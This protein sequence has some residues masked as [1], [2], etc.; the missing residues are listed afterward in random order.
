MVLHLG[1][2]EWVIVDS[3][4]DSKTKRPC[5]LTYLEGIGVDLQ[6]VKYIIATHW[7]DDHIRGLGDIYVKCPNARLCYSN[8]IKN[9]TFL[10]MV[11]TLA[12]KSG[13]ETSGV[14]TLFQIFDEG[15]RRVLNGDYLGVSP[16]MA[17]LSITPL[18]SKF[19]I[20]ALSPSSPI[21]VQAMASL[22]N[23]MPVRGQQKR[24]LIAPS[25]N[26]TA[27]VLWI[28]VGHRK[29]LL[30]ADLEESATTQGEWTRLLAIAAGRSDAEVFKIPHHGSANGDHPGVWT[31]MLTPDPVAL[32]TPYSRLIHPLPT[33]SDIAR[34]RS[35]TPNASITKCHS[36]PNPLS[37][38]GARNKMIRR[39]SINYRPVPM[40]TGQ[41]RLRAPIFGPAQWMTRLFGTAC[42]L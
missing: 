10:A 27:V 21:C 33:A 14:D 23:L 22:A 41:I 17:N 18:L 37:R 11:A 20:V 39:T 13:T 34:I 29:V 1:E 30:G 9:R 28:Q 2:N 8:A 35:R 5:A 32:L 16:V 3:C 24:R 26:E 12:R 4:I 19:Q 15:A 6:N 36:A 31:T 40:S 42:P 38:S 25:C 7:H